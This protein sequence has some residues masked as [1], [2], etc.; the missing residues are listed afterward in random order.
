MA[1]HSNR[2]GRRLAWFRLATVALLAVGCSSLTDPLLK[3][4][5][6]DNIPSGATQSIA[7]AEGLRLGA[8]YRLVTI[9]AGADTAGLFEIV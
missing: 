8:L 3:A 2:P 4:H 6:P 5:D 9:T 1:M 7:G